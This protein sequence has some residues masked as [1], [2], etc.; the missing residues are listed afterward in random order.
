MAEIACKM[1]HFVSVKEFNVWH[2]QQVGSAHFFQWNFEDDI[3]GPI[4]VNEITQKKVICWSSSSSFY[5]NV[6]LSNCPSYPV[7]IRAW[8]ASSF[9]FWIDQHSFATSSLVSFD[10]NTSRL[11]RQAC[12]TPSLITAPTFAYAVRHFDP[13]KCLLE[14]THFNVALTLRN[15]PAKQWQSHKLW[16]RRQTLISLQP[17][18]DY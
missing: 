4:R 7:C 15:N 1:E 14:S 17:C 10:F 18:I 16:L 5:F 6:A 3:L 12:V 13:W 2:T 8:T 9:A 11:L